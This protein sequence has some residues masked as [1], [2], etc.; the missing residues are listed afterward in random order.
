MFDDMQNAQK[1]MSKLHMASLITMRIFRIYNV[2]WYYM[3]NNRMLS[4]A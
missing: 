3:E 4:V 1:I 2:I